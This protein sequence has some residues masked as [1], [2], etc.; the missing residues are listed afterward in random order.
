MKLTSKSDPF[1]TLCAS[2]SIQR[3]KVKDE[4]CLIFDIGS[5]C[6]WFS[7]FHQD[8]DRRASAGPLHLPKVRRVFHICWQEG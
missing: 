5:V 8:V 2:E 7:V 3:A 4:K 1:L 6:L